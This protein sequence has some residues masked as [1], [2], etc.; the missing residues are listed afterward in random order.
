MTPEEKELYWHD[1]KQCYLRTWALGL[2]M[3]LGW[4]E[5]QTMKWATKWEDSLDEPTRLFYHRPAEEWMA[6]ELVPEQL[7][8]KILQEGGSGLDVLQLEWRLMYCI[9][10]TIVGKEVED[11]NDSDWRLTAEPLNAILGEY[12]EKLPRV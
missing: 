3:L 10:D 8:R 9:Q 1:T 4:T 6:H 11:Y 5:Q 2:K 12:G 7:K